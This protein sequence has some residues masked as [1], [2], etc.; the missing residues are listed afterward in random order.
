MEEK[1]TKEIIR[2]ELK[3]LSGLTWGQRLGYIWDYYKPIMAAI[4]AV[5]FLISIGVTIYRNKQI[6]DLLKVYLLNSN[7]YGIDSERMVNE[8][9]EWIGGI[10]EKQ[11]ILIDTTL[12]IGDDNS[13][14]GMANQV[15]LTAL[16]S[17]GDIDVMLMDEETFDSYYKVGYFADL[18]EVLPEERLNDWQDFLIYREPVAESETEEAAGLDS[19]TEKEDQASGADTTG[20]RA[21]DQELVAVALDLTDS[22]VLKEQNAYGEERV[23]GCIMVNA[24]R[25]ELCDDFFSYLM[26]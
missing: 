24:G 15:K 23:Y 19:E 14:Y 4:L 26:Q 9:T 25:L 20:E 12:S 5:I 2:E 6:Q 21:E 11:E 18:T 7:S 1:Q 10:E 16:A 8:F 17:V 13:Q 3:K 22:S